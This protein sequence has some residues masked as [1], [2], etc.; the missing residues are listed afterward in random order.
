LYTR[1]WI[2]RIFFAQQLCF[3]EIR[4]KKFCF[5]CAPVRA[6]IEDE[7]TTTCHFYY[8]PLQPLLCAYNKNW[9]CVSS[10]IAIVLVY[11]AEINSVY[12]YIYYHSGSSLQVPHTEP[13]S[14]SSGRHSLVGALYVIAYDAYT[15]CRGSTY[16]SSDLLG[17]LHSCR[18]WRSSLH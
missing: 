4:L 5:S 10:L 17:H 8:I 7:N 3:G 2:R 12:I 14:L 16:F 15:V 9:S 11:C 18:R 1:R 13:F 6:G